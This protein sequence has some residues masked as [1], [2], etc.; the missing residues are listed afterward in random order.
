MVAKEFRAR[1]FTMLAEERRCSA[2]ERTVEAALSA[3]AL[4]AKGQVLRDLKVTSK[5]KNGAVLCCG[6]NSSKFREGDSVILLTGHGQIKARI[7]SISDGGKRLDVA[8]RSA[9][10]GKSQITMMESSDDVAAVFSIALA[11]LSAGAPGWWLLDVLAG[12]ERGKRHLARPCRDSMEPL[13]RQLCKESGLDVDARFH[14]ALCRCLE[15]PR[16]FAIQGPPGTGK[17]VLLALVA[18]GLA[19]QGLRVAVTAHTHQA[20]NN[21]LSSIHGLFPKRRVA[22]LGSGVRRE[23]L[24]DDI[25]C[26]ILKDEFGGQDGKTVN[27]T[28]F[29]ITFAAATIELSIQQSLF[30]PHA[31]LIDEAGQLP[32]PYACSM[33]LMGAS[34]YLLF[35]DDRQMPPVFRT[36]SSLNVDAVSIFVRFREHHPQ[37]VVQLEVTHRL[38]EELC[39]AVSRV[40][41]EGT[42]LAGLTPSPLAR[43]RRLVLAGEHRH[44]VGACALYVNESLCWLDSPPGDSRE[45]NGWEAMRAVEIIEAALAGGLAASDIAVIVP[46][47][48]QVALIRSMFSARL[49]DVV[50]LPIVDTVERLQ[51]MTVE[52]IV[53]SATAADPDYVSVIGDFLF[54]VNRLNVA[55]SRARTKAIVIG[56]SGLWDA[57]PMTMLG[58]DGQRVWKHF[59]DLARVI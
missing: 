1:L 30:A 2:D 25:P 26:L 39:A 48:R 38:N 6:V 51:G 54:S 32:L 29:G 9:R 53:L 35:G 56:S 52:L 8:C 10:L 55:V 47:R 45:T 58:L 44:S 15:Q 7:R 27:A 59:R 14:A 12:S 42:G 31:V 33:G 24:S 49:C 5:T 50:Q 41:Y 17:T 20:V 46:F 23:G 4:E 13:A 57:I 22:K 19:R 36:D 34:C 3:A 40:F 18:E 11:K 43:S 21:A 37:H 28:I 16:L